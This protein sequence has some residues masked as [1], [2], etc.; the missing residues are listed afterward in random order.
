MLSS[1]RLSDGY[2]EVV[3]PLPPGSVLLWLHRAVWLLINNIVA[4]L[5]ILLT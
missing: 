4:S 3:R 2:K 1:A 5:V